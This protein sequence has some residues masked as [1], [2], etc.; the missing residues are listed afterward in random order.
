MPLVTNSKDSL[1]GGVNQQAAEHRLPTQVKESINVFPTINTGLLKRNPTSKVGL[2]D[3]IT[4]T[5]DMWTYAYDRGLIGDNEEKYSIHI[6]KDGMQIIDVTTGEVFTELNGGLVFDN[7]SAKEYL[8][9]FSGAN[10][11][12]AVTIKDTTFLLNKHTQPKM[13]DRSYDGVGTST[14][15]KYYGTIG[16]KPSSKAFTIPSTVFSSSSRAENGT[17]VFITNS[18]PNRTKAY[19][20]EYKYYSE[21]AGA[22][23]T[24]N[25]TIFDIKGS[26]TTITIDGYKTSLTQTPIYGRSF[27]GIRLASIRSI[28]RYSEWITALYERIVDILPSNEYFVTIVNGDDIR[29]TRYDGVATA[30][31]FSIDID[32]SPFQ[33]PSGEHLLLATEEINNTEADYHTGITYASTSDSI[34]NQNTDYNKDGF[35]WIKSSNPSSAYL[36]RVTLTDSVGNTASFSTTQTTTESAASALASAINAHAN[37]SATFKGSIVKATAL[38]GDMKNVE[39]SDS[40]GNLASFGWSNSVSN[41]TELPKKLGFDNAVVF[42]E[43][44]IS[45]QFS[46]YWLKYSDGVWVET[47]SPFV[48]TIIN[49]T[50]MPHVLVREFDDTTG[51]IKFRLSQYDKWGI[52][53][54]GDDDSN[55]E[56]SFITDGAIKDM[57]FFKNRFGFITS[58]TIVMSEVGNYGNFFRTSVATL[59]D[60]DRIDTTVDTTKAIALEYATYLEDSLLIFSDK[61][62]FKVEGGTILSPKSIQVSQTSAYEINKN[63]RPIFMNDKVFF[64][65]KRGAYTAVMQYHIYGDGRISEAVDITSHVEKYIPANINTLS[66]SSINNMLFI[67][68]VDTPDTVYTYKYFDNNQERIQSAWFKWEYNGELYGAFTLGR[69]LNVL[70]N[71][72]Q[73]STVS[74]WI[75]GDGIWNSE[76]LWTSDGIWVASPESLTASKNF[77]I[78]PIHPQDHTGYFIDA[79]EFIEDIEKVENV[80]KTATSSALVY[81][82]NVQML[83]TSSISIDSSL[84]GLY[85]IDVVT[86]LGNN[87]SSVN[88]PLDLPRNPV[89]YVTSITITVNEPV[90]TVFTGFNFN[91]SNQTQQLLHNSLFQDGITGWTFTDWTINYGEKD[92]GSTIPVRVDLGEWVFKSNG[93]SQTRGT[94][95]FKTCQ[96][97]SEDGSDFELEISDIKRESVRTVKSRYTVDRK[98]MVYGDSRNIRLAILNN[99]ENGFRINSVSLEGNYNSRNRRTS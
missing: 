12:S 97:N 54:F 17:E 22:W 93:V 82:C 78:Q 96:I 21:R 40:Y 68:S 33:T 30:I 38:S 11:Y 67:T 53:S 75:L 50:T 7:Q 16:L 26:T 48:E 85:N 8:A 57:F 98:P 9:P 29:V 77:E 34:V 99:S 86:S 39:T 42:I 79:S 18:C 80:T 88:A 51:V 6:T 45:S 84:I 71:R 62:Q 14:V 65:T 20:F 94:L 74:D 69:N 32:S 63:I 90:D 3:N 5:S 35:I 2:S 23:I 81:S 27:S 91:Y 95:K 24:T 61:S 58:R 47:V 43:G 66:G 72:Y 25:R 83:Y 1:Y 44:D 31:S 55:P 76:E 56:P 89:D 70:I 28:L 49:E 92:I 46:G 60:S 59:L 19:R 15:T 4:Y 87:Y 13:I 52:R 41:Y 64:C 36:Y 10:G 73:A 37:F